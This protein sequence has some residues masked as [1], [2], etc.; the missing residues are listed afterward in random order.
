MHLLHESIS[1]RFLSPEEIFR[2]D[3]GVRCMHNQMM[4]GYMDVHKIC[5]IGEGRLGSWKKV[6]ARVLAGESRILLFPSGGWSWILRQPVVTEGATHKS[7]GE[8]GPK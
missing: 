7:L 4:V 8:F 6:H 5:R 3:L 1:V 2:S